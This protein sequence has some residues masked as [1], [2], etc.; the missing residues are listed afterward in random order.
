MGDHP[1]S[2]TIGPNGRIANKRIPPFSEVTI[3][4]LA[5][6]RMTETNQTRMH[7]IVEGRVQGVG[8]RYFV[9]EVAELLGVSGWVRNRWDE[10]VEVL[11]E[12][13]KTAL[14]E[15]LDALERG[16][17]GASVSSVKTDWEKPTGEFHSFRVA[18]TE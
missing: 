6:S 8:F 18:M 15:L 7:A 5:E 16:P 17:R 14:D 12:G 4:G 10:T 3:T 13:E 9:L 1:G 11:A 2:S